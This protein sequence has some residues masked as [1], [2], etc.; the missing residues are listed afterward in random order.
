MR[1]ENEVS[2]CRLLLNHSGT[3]SEELGRVLGHL[4]DLWRRMLKSECK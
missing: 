1:D 4:V 2:K 3:K